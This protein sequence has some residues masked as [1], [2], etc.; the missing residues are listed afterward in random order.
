MQ[1][2]IQ[3]QCLD[4]VQRPDHRFDRVSAELLERRDALVTVNDQITIRLMGNSDDDDRSL[5]CRSS[6]RRQ[7]LSLSLGMADPQVFM[8]TVQLVKLQ[9]HAVSSPNPNAATGRI[10]DC[11]EEG[12]S[13]P[14][15]L[16]K[17]VR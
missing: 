16:A 7:Q 2:T 14:E 10:W 3:H 4:F 8:A 17:S 5:L 15:S 13:V 6:Q 12:G 1:R 9:F 11:A